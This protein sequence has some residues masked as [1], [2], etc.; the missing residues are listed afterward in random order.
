MPPVLH[1]AGRPRWCAPHAPALNIAARKGRCNHGRL[2][3]PTGSDE[4]TLAPRRGSPLWQFTKGLARRTRMLPSRLCGC[5]TRRR[6]TSKEMATT[7]YRLLDYRG[8]HPARPRFLVLV[9][10]NER[11]SSTIPYNAAANERERGRTPRRSLFCIRRTCGR[12]LFLDVLH[13]FRLQRYMMGFASLY[14]SYLLS[15]KRDSRC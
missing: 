12:H 10:L 15:W 4:P 9:T 13:H 8:R 7:H 3:V 2:E 1:N 6:N 11:Q 5:G 14:W